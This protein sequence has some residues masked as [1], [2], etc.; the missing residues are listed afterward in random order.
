[1]KYMAIALQFAAAFT[2]L[3]AA[4]QWYKAS[5]IALPGRLTV[6]TPEQVTAAFSGAPDAPPGGVHLTV[7]SIVELH[8]CLVAATS[9]NKSAAFWTGAVVALTALA[10]VFSTW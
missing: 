7:N 3:G 2:G 10:E 4:Y 9:L 1:M 6:E 5:A 8:A